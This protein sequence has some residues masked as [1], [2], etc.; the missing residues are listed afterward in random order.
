[1]KLRGVMC[2]KS[3]SSAMCRAAAT[4]ASANFGAADNLP[5][6]VLPLLATMPV[7]QRTKTGT[8]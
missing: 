1:M 4:F 7:V 6:S 3:T 2:S 5:L 8:P